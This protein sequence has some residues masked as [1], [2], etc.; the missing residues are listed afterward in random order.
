MC[1]GFFLGDNLFADEIVDFY[2]IGGSKGLI[3]AGLRRGEGAAN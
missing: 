3:T 1:E 2:L